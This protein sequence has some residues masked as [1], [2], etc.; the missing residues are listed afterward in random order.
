M[1]APGTS[2]LVDSV[3][4][5]IDQKILRAVSVGFQPIE[6][7][8]RKNGGW[9]YTKAALHEVSVV[10]VPANPNAVALA[11]SFNP[12]IAEKLLVRADSDEVDAI[13]KGQ[14]TMTTPNLNKARERLRSLGIDL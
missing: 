2:E 10:A 9:E 6:A 12:Q 4:S 1:A 8:P 13:F 3:R 11:K 7:E 5:L 14:S